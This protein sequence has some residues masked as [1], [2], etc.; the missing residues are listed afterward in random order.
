MNPMFTQVGAACVANANSDE[1]VYWTMLF[2]ADQ[3]SSRQSR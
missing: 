3:S 2:G 1:G